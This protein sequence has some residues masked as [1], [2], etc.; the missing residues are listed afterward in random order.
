MVFIKIQCTLFAFHVLQQEDGSPGYDKG[1]QE[2]RTAKAV[3]GCEN[4][5]DLFTVKKRQNEVFVTEC[6]LRLCRD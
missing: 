3:F 4:G 2:E 5:I 1:Q 6:K